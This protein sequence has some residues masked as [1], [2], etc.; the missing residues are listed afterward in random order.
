M[1]VCLATTA[2]CTQAPTQNSADS[3]VQEKPIAKRILG[4]SLG[5]NTAQFYLRKAKDI[6]DYGFDEIYVTSRAGFQIGLHYNFAISPKM[7]LQIAPQLVLYDWR[8]QFT[9]TGSN[10]PEAVGLSPVSLGLPILL[11]L[12]LTDKGRNSLYAL[13]GFRYSY[14]LNKG[15]V[16]IDG[17][18]FDGGWPYTK[19][20]SLNVEIGF[21]KEWLR[22]HTILGLEMKAYL[23][24]NDLR[25]ADQQIFITTSNLDM[26]IKHL[27]PCLIMLSFCF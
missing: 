6:A 22:K 7:D 20:H 14:D 1:L 5:L 25:I 8:I 15:K 26:A 24:L 13:G 11:K 10:V 4:F 17:I 18:W 23:G 12:Y 3:L 2:N 27:R 16:E 21:G 9:N 19:P